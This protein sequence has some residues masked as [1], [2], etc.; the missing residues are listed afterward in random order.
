[1]PA[2]DT[3]AEGRGAVVER[4]GVHLGHVGVGRWRE[5]ERLELAE[6]R[7]EVAVLCIGELL[8]TEEDDEMV[9]Q[10]LLDHLDLG[11]RQRLAQVDSRDLCADDTCDGSDSDGHGHHLLTYRRR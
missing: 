2:V 3:R 1:M 9:E 11:G 10:R 6:L 7:G 8:I 4:E 5:H